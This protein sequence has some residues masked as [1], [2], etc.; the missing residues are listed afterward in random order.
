MATS[1]GVPDVLSPPLA[2][3]LAASSSAADARLK[4]ID[5]EALAALEFYK[6]KDTSKGRLSH[7]G[8]LSCV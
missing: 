7:F 4:D 8:N 6:Q 5:P 2:P 3:A 1:P